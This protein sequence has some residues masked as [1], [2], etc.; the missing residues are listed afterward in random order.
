MKTRSVTRLENN[1]RK[2][3]RELLRII[4]TF[5]VNHR[6]QM[7]HVFDEMLYN[8]SLTFCGNDMCEQEISIYD[9]IETKILGPDLAKSH[10]PQLLVNKNL[11]QS[12]ET[13]G[14][15]TLVGCTVSPGFEFS[16]F[17][18]APKNFIPN[19]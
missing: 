12:A 3:P 18:L 13:T 2:L 4:D 8:A 1:L 16:K 10:S 6:K 9:A 7:I 5:N 14:D 11:W 15:Y 17:I 19:D